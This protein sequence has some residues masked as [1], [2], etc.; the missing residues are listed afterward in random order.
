MPKVVSCYLGK[1]TQSFP[2]LYL[3]HSLNPIYCKSEAILFVPPSEFLS[4]MNLKYSSV[5]NLVELHHTLKK[6]VPTLLKLNADIWQ[7][8]SNNI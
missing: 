7:K 1:R 3:C 5:K 4:D 6:N 8:V 2:K